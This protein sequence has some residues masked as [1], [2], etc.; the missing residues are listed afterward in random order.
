MGRLGGSVDEVSD[1]G[2]PGCDLTVRELEPHI[3]LCADPAEPAWHSL[4]LPLSLPHPPLALS[5]SQINKL[6]RSF[7]MR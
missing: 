2:F 1:S 5:L 7:L 3:R 4:S 6:K